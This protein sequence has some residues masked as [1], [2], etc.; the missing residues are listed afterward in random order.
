MRINIDRHGHFFTNLQVKLLQTIFAEH[1]EAAFLGILLVSFDNKILGLPGSRAT[2]GNTTTYLGCK[3]DFSLN[4]HC[5]VNVVGCE[6]STFS[7]KT[8]PITRAFWEEYFTF[9]NNFR[10]ISARLL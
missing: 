8:P 10:T 3:N 7:D 6:V 5:V 2:L 9:V 4:I 1:C